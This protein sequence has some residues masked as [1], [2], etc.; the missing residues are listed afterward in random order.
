VSFHADDRDSNTNHDVSRIKIEYSNRTITTSDHGSPQI[1]ADH[2]VKPD[3][4]VFD[5]D[6]A[7]KR[8][9]VVLCA[10]TYGVPPDV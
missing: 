2:H 6:K 7:P 10:A 4:R 3:S 5:Q 1:T 8:A 9:R